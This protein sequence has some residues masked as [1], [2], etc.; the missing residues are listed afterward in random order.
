[1]IISYIK[2]QK[3]TYVVSYIDIDSNFD[4][5]GPW[6]RVYEY[7]LIWKSPRLRI[8]HKMHLKNFEVK[9][10]SILNILIKVCRT[11]PELNTV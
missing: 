2:L 4:F 5:F 10:T 6:Q 11:F 9:H 8:F 7:M 1:M 3:L